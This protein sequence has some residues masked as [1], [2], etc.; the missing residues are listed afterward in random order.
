MFAIKDM[1]QSLASL[2]V[3]SNG[4]KRSTRNAK[5]YDMVGGQWDFGDRARGPVAGRERQSLNPRSPAPKAG[6]LTT[7]P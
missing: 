5:K 1:R 7:T 2:V 4:K 6:M 3:M